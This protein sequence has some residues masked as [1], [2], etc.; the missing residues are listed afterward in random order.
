LAAAERGIALAQTLGFSNQAIKH[1]FVHAIEAALEI[2]DREKAEQLVVAIEGIPPGLRPPFLDAQAHRF[3]ARLAS[4][5]SD[6]ESGY[7]PGAA[8]F[9]ELEIPFWLAVALLEHGELLAEQGRS[10]DAEP[11]LA[12]ARALF[13]QLGATPWLE[14]AGGRVELEATA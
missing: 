13:E 8:R 9:R 3:R 10:D 2:G 11:L 4:M 14:R 7:R 5:A 1:S 12:E 6:A